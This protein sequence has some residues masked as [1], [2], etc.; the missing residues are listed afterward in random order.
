MLALVQT[1]PLTFRSSLLITPFAQNSNQNPNAGRESFSGHVGPHAE[2]ADAVE[3]AIFVSARTNFL[4]F[5]P[6]RA[7]NS[8]IGR[9][10]KDRSKPFPIE[11]QKLAQ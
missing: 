5:S 11:A 4:V 7:L 10:L 9:C 1:K 6:T 3:L 8:F 2:A